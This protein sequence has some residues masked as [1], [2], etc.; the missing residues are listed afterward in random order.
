MCFAEHALVYFVCMHTKRR[1]CVSAESICLLNAAQ[2]TY[3][4]LPSCCIQAH[5]L[6]ECHVSPLGAWL[7]TALTATAAALCSYVITFS[8]HLR[9][10]VVL[11]T[12]LGAGQAL[13]GRGK[14][15]DAEQQL[16]I[17]SFVCQGLWFKLSC[18]AK[19]GECKCFW[20]GRCVMSLTQVLQV[21]GWRI[22]ALNCAQAA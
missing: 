10:Y 2:S 15:T 12:A 22:S 11:L 21:L 14:N 6:A 20:L 17:R 13:V 3:Y 18:W 7:K 1:A 19:P 9:A 4:D 8:V 5:N 16:R